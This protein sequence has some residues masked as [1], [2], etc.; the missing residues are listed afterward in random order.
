M[1]EMKILIAGNRSQVAP[2]VMA[3]GKHGIEA[4]DTD[5]VEEIQGYRERE[6]AER[7]G[8]IIGNQNPEAVII[9]TEREYRAVLAVRALESGCHVLIEPPISDTREE[10]A[11]IVDAAERAEK[12]VMVAY[13]NAYRPGLLRVFSALYSGRFGAVRTTDLIV[14]SK[15]D[16]K[17]SIDRITKEA[18]AYRFMEEIFA[19][20]ICT[21]NLVARRKCSLFSIDEKRTEYP[22]KIV[23]KLDYGNSAAGMVFFQSTGRNPHI[24]GEFASQGMEVPEESEFSEELRIVCDNGEIG[25]FLTGD[26]EL[27]M[28]KR[29]G[30]VKSAY[31]MRGS[32]TESEVLHFVDFIG[33]NIT[34][35]VDA[36]KAA[37]VEE[38]TCRL[39][40]F[41]E[42]HH[43]ER[44]K[45]ITESTKVP[46]F[47]RGLVEPGGRKAYED[48]IV[49]FE[50]YRRR[51]DWRFDGFRLLLIE[52]PRSSLD[53]ARRKYFPGMALAV[54]AGVAGRHGCDVIT[55]DLN[56]IVL[57]SGLLTDDEINEVWG[58]HVLSDS[59]KM[60]GL[61]EKIVSSLPLGGMDMMAFSLQEDSHFEFTKA[62]CRGMKKI[63]SAPIVLGGKITGDTNF[64]EGCADFAVVGDGE[65]ALL[66]VIKHIVEGW[67]L[68]SI[69][70]LLFPNSH[71]NLL[72]NLLTDIRI[73]GVPEYNP[74]LMNIYNK[75][76][77]T[78]YPYMFVN[79][80]P[81]KCSFCASLGFDRHGVLDIPEVLGQLRRINGATGARHFYF[82]NHLLNLNKS[83]LNGFLDGLLDQDF[84]IQ[85][86]DSACLYGI[87]AETA[88][89][90]RRAGCR[91]ICWGL[92]AG[93]DRLLKITRKTI[94]IEGIEDIL[95]IC[96][97]A[98][99]HN[100]VNFIIGLP[101]ETPDDLEQAMRFAERN[102]KIISKINYVSY[103][104]AVGSPAYTEPAKH[105]LI[106]KGDTFD[107]DGGL[108]WAAKMEY[109]TRAYETAHGFFSD[110][111]KEHKMT[112]YDYFA[113]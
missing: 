80:C 95:R 14:H 74:D 96:N 41:F 87:D 13:H 73:R 101:H 56:R 81:N 76:G 93:S 97:N 75:D 36:R 107:E 91:K 23:V 92:D 58:G 28:L 62:L 44:I 10:R 32:E 60:D 5:P 48:K 12:K 99:I 42:E 9:V 47:W 57:K 6:A 35:F 89:N 52:P 108:K 71:D 30:N 83:Y 16:F 21:M 50:E 53:S 103:Y 64:M 17:A 82:L 7:L 88:G 70:G 3:L 24:I 15:P 77:V 22:G 40:V 112:E 102:S 27:L 18:R 111:E 38:S 68:D 31:F 51:V 61:A 67:P 33:R 1:Q 2:W 79:G 104:Y 69:P 8:S 59:S 94:R 4:N 86:S 11:A 43:H 19:G 63:S 34:P 85:W 98:G 37:D 20:Y 105:G 25:W 65:I 49:T 54:L 106:K 84:K 72:I 78:I 29:G 100:E 26:R 55:D 110:F 39:L 46:E 45:K 109:N 113:E 66:C 90:M